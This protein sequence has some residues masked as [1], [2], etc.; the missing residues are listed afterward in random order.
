M[1]CCRRDSPTITDIDL[2]LAPSK[3]QK[4]FKEIRK[5]RGEL[6]L[7]QVC[8]FGTEKTKNAILAACRGYRSAEY[9]EGIDNDEALYI[10]SL[11]PQERGF[12]WE[13][14]D[15]LYGNE[16]KGRAPQKQF[17][18]AVN[19]YPGLI[20][21]IKNIGGLISRR[22][23]HASG[24][25][26]FDAD[27]I[28]E[29]AAIMRAPNG[30][31]TTQ[32]DLH[33]QEAAGSVKYDF[34]LTQ[35]QDIIIQ[36]VEFLQRDGLM[37]PD[38]SLREA[39]DKYLHPEVLPIDNKRIWE[40]LANNEVLS[41]FQFDSAVGAQAARKIKPTNPVEMA[42]ANGLMRLM[43]AERGAESPLDKYVRF[44]NN[45]SLWYKE[46]SE[47]GLTT[48]EQKTLEPYFLSS[49]GVPPSQEQMMRMLMDE[50]I[51]GFTLAEANSSRKIVGKKLMEKI[52]EL[53]KKVLERAASPALGKY[54]W[55]CGLGP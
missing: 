53:H 21:I 31:L 23:I 15:I 28:Y 12:L 27:N 42:D 18:T 9:P 51:C 26:L 20:D 33:D 50:N 43:T 16:E 40:A 24:V 25:I 19:Q 48:A 32:W 49:Y 29:T 14:D 54:V 37:D 1:Y 10:S 22:G 8:T 7:V 5:E 46:M 45:I 52:P 2:D 3:L 47:A 41:C 11:V 6:G 35:V 55:E 13:L 17:I 38:L 44:K 4:I 30:A 39:Y 34:L 36:T